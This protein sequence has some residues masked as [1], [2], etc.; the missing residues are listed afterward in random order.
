MIKKS[1]KDARSVGVNKIIC[2]DYDIN[3]LIILLNMSISMKHIP[4]MYTRM[5]TICTHTRN[6]MHTVSD[7]ST[8]CSVYEQSGYQKLLREVF[9]SGL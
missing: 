1:V 5:L 6:N 7:R 4:N 9:M 3:T 2:C 8:S